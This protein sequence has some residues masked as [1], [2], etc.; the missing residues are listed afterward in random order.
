MCEELRER[1]DAFQRRGLSDINLVAL[2]LDA[3]IRDALAAVVVVMPTRGPRVR[4]TGAGLATRRHVPTVLQRA[5]RGGQRSTHDSGCADHGFWFQGPPSHRVIPHAAA[6]R[7]TAGAFGSKLGFARKYKPCPRLSPPGSGPEPR[8]GSGMP[9]TPCVRMHLANLSAARNWLPVARTPPVPPG[10]SRAHAR[11]A[12]LNAGVPV[13]ARLVGP[14]P[15]LGS[16][17]LGTPCARMQSANSIAGEEVREPVVLLGLCEDPQAASATTQLTAARLP[18]TLRLR[19][20]LT[21]LQVV[22][23]TALQRR[24]TVTALLRQLGI[25]AG[26]SYGPGRK[27]LTATAAVAGHGGPAAQLW[28]IPFPSGG[29]QVVAVPKPVEAVCMSAPAG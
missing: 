17:K 1:F 3:S 26:A 25:L 11:L 19:G 10:A 20:S 12:D 5:T 8:V 7:R 22:P 14:P 6:A 23:A 9:G 27:R 21:L 2:F 29:G 4:L 24:N 28:S 13:P 16:G 18:P 15:S